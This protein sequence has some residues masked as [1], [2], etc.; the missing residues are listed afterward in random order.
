MADTGHFDC[1]KFYLSDR[2]RQAGQIA[3]KAYI[4]GFMSSSSSSTSWD[5]C[6]DLHFYEALRYQWTNNNRNN[7]GFPAADEWRNMCG[8]KSGYKRLSGIPADNTN[9]NY[10]RRRVV[11]HLHL[12]RPTWATGR[13]TGRSTTANRFDWAL[14]NIMCRDRWE[15]YPGPWCVYAND[16]IIGMWLGWT[17]EHL[18]SGTG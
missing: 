5:L 18:W 15:I 12:R 7:L 11:C 4:S 3:V 6:D 8:S 17:V 10:T 16:V 1:A 9:N 2:G 13:R 14:K